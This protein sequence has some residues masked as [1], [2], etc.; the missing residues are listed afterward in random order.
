M[1]LD[2]SKHIN[3]NSKYRYLRVHTCTF[4]L[5]R[6]FW[7]N[8]DALS[9]M[10]VTVKNMRLFLILTLCLGIR[11]WS[12]KQKDASSSKYLQPECYQFAPSELIPGAS[13]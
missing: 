5:P 4:I 1:Y 12:S 3:I 10:S 13:P 6:V 9:C 8:T 7:T 11:F 2:R